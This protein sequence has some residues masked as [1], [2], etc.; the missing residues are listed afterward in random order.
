MANTKPFI[1][2][3]GTY[4][5]IITNS[6][7]GNGETLY[8]GGVC[9]AVEP[10]VPGKLLICS[11]VGQIYYDTDD[12]RRILLSG[13][14]SSA[15]S[16]IKTFTVT[17]TIIDPALNSETVTIHYKLS[18]VPTDLTLNGVSL[19]K[20][21]EGSQIMTI[22]EDTIFTLNAVVRGSSQSKSVSCM[23]IGPVYW[24]NAT[25]TTVTPDNF[26]EFTSQLLDS[27]GSV[28][29]TSLPSS[30]TFSA[31]S[32]N[33]YAYYVVPKKLAPNGVTFTF[34]GLGAGGFCDAE[35]GSNPVQSVTYNNCEY[36]IYRSNDGG[37]TDSLNL[38]LSKS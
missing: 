34:V 6:V 26:S 36:L 11:D 4:N 23:F 18:S 16:L 3:D 32:N 15:E 25:A 9:I 28:S 8:D 17:P 30:V 37:F 31:M 29:T 10:V 38:A 21:S 5:D 13:G 33:E 12:N 7:D 27:G 1:F 22:N 19:S 35:D 20:S 14:G 2:I 24:G